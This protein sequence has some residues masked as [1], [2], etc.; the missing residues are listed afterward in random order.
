MG[1]T[2]KLKKF[3]KKRHFKLSRTIRPP[4]K[5]SMTY[6]GPEWRNQR[7]LLFSLASLCCYKVWGI[8]VGNLVFLS[9]PG[10][11]APSSVEQ[12][13][14]RGPS[15]PD[16]CPGSKVHLGSKPCPALKCY[17]FSFH[18]VNAF[19]FILTEA[20]LQWAHI[21][22]FQQSCKTGVITLL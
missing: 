9:I 8:N 1:K 4:G 11:Q 12:M 10:W 15:H 3:F 20:H 5:V 6:Y 22:S 21:P 17:G 19:V 16:P 2:A 7:E 13:D 14:L 18:P